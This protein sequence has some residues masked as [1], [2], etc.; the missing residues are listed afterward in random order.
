MKVGRF[1][2]VAILIAALAQSASAR[3]AQRQY[4]SKAD[5]DAS[6]VAQTTRDDGRQHCGQ[7]AFSVSVGNPAFKDRLDLWPLPCRW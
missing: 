3:R 4:L 6:R 5:G 2:L 7:R 1:V